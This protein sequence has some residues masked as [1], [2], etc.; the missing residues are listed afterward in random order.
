MLVFSN[1]FHCSVTMNREHFLL[2]S[3]ELCEL[4][5]Q[6]NKQLIKC[7]LNLPPTERAT[8][9][10]LYPRLLSFIKDALDEICNFCLPSAQKPVGYLECPF[11][12]KDG[13]VPHLLLNE[14]SMESITFCKVMDT[15]VPEEY[16]AP[17]FRSNCKFICHT[18][19]QIT[20]CFLSHDSYRCR[21]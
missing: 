8:E 5:V 1:S 11:N 19:Y 10:C 2:E 14:I 9:E 13:E 17:L 15:L 12:H 7:Y 18:M 6:W 21:F 3:K 16:Y 20:S 4:D